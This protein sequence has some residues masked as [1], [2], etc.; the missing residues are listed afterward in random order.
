MTKRS[1]IRNIIISAALYVILN[2]S[3]TFIKASESQGLLTVSETFSF[4]YSLLFYLPWIPLLPLL[5]HL[6]RDK[7]FKGSA[8][9]LVLKVAICFVGTIAVFGLLHTIYNRLV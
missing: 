5:V 7:R 8:G 1:V 6:F 9:W 3:W 4:A 2:V